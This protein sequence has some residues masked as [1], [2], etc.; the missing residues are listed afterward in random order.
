MIAYADS[1]IDEAKSLLTKVEDIII[2]PLMTLLMAVA[3]LL[4]L[5]GAYEFV[6]GATDD[7]A[8]SKGKTH[9]LYGIIGLLVMISAYA[10]LSIATNTFGIGIPA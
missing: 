1:H 4:F 5:Y 7:T 3:F 8:R 6:L 2:F 9:M 10:I